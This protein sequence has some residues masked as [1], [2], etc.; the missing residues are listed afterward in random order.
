MDGVC[1]LAYAITQAGAR[2]LLLELAVRGF[3]NY[4]DIMLRE[5]CQAQ[6]RGRH[7]R[8]TCL[9][10]QPTLFDT[11]IPVAGE[12]GYTANIRWSTRRNLEVLLGDEEGEMF[13][14]QFPNTGV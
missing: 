6:G 10:V 1:T 9:T 7:A 2:K 5:W 11:H 3:D 12:R 14:D 4:F 8:H 13:E